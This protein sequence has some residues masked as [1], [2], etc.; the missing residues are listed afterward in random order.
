M[1]RIAIVL[2]IFQILFCVCISQSQSIILLDSGKNTSIRGLSV[3]TNSVAWISGS[4]GYTALTNDAGK[5]WKWKQ[6]SGY[7]RLDFRDIEAF[8]DHEAVIVSAGTPAVILKTS[9]GGSSWKEVYRNNS[10][11]IFLDGMDFWNKDHGLVY[12]DPIK[13]KMQLLETRDGGNTWRDIST[14]LTIELAEGEA[15][16]AAS[17]TAIRTGKRG[18][19]WIATG[20]MQSRIFHSDDFGK[21]WEVYKCPILQGN[22]SSGP[23]SLATY[24]GKKMVAAGGNY[25]IDTLRDNSLMLSSDGGKTWTQ[26]ISQLFGYRSA[27]EYISKNIVIATGT[28]GTDLST[29][30][31][32][33]WRNISAGGFNSVR[34]A[35]KGNLVLLTGLKG[36]IARLQIF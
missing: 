5:T 32:Q 33:T 18:N 21:T 29:D 11:D 28:S 35:K 2:T 22:N 17:G 9:D 19:V 1:K 34:K 30:G 25:L 10:A 31:G 3:V 16:F 15:S 26:P 6:L 8:S 7:E 36:K 24:Q 12:G 13:G 20:G 4:N 27:I 14:N 23:F